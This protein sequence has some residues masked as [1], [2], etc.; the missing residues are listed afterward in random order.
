MPD[1]I[2][3]YWLLA[4]VCGVV[5]PVV[6]C[7]R[8]AEPQHDAT[9]QPVEVAAGPGLHNVYRVTDRLLSGSSP[10]GDDGFRSLQFLGV[11]TV[12]SVDGAKPDV[13]R[14]RRFEMRY[15]HIPVGYDG[16]PS[17]VGERIARAVRDL[18]GVVYLHCHHG[19]HRGPAA[20][21]V[22]WRCLDAGCP[23]ETALAW[24]RAAGTDPKYAG[25][26]ASVERARPM[27]AAELDRVT[28]DFPEYAPVPAL[29]ALMVRIDERW[30]HLK[31]V[32]AAGWQVPPTHPDIDP[33][34]EAVQLAEL[35]R[36][37]AR[38]RGSE[39]RGAGFVKMLQEAGVSA[40]SLEKALRAKPVD[41]DAATREFN[42][43]GELCASCHTKFRDGPATK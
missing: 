40:D 11:K 34:H 3:R 20:A 1:W 5:S 6:G 36:E 22:A 24:L 14:A 26:Y 13:E 17:E 33:P 43:S 21:A 4:C 12:I 35:Y 41:G 25:L 18:P 30:D 42:R 28:S 37:A 9:P 38:L 7:R 32:K 2:P 27:M 39:E 15:V 23:A 16:V 19:K 8:Q 29:A 10:V 31:D